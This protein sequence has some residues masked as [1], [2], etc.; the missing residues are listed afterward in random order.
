MGSLADSLTRTF[1]LG[2]LLLSLTR[3]LSLYSRVRVKGKMGSSRALPSPR[4]LLDY[5]RGPPLFLHGGVRHK[6]AYSRENCIALIQVCFELD[7][8]LLL[9]GVQLPRRF[10][11][12]C[13]GAL[14]VGSLVVEAALESVDL[15]L[16][17]LLL[18]VPWD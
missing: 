8:T 5:S 3:T 11:R 4:L 7:D 17:R 15:L 16:Q 6:C 12:C 14:S 9:L 2:S 18:L 1:V 13:N 10:A